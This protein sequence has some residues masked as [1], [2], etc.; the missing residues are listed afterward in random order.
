VQLEP[1]PQGFFAAHCNFPLLQ[2]Q[3]QV[4]L[5]AQHSEHDETVPTEDWSPKDRKRE[6]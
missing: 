6:L 1:A 2:K 5:P 3:R 4:K